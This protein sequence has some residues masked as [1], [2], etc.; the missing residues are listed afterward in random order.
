MKALVTGS[1]GL[2]GS[3]CVRMLSEL[4]WD[5]IGLENDM[6]RTFLGVAASTS[7]TSS[8]LRRT[9]PRFH[10]VNLDIRDRQAIRDLFQSERP[11]FIIHTAAQPASD[12]S[13]VIPYE[14][15]DVNATGTLNLLVAARDFTRDSPFCFTSTAKVYG[16][17]PNTIP[18]VMQ[19]SRYDFADARDGIDEA[20]PL[21]Q[22]RHS[23]FGVSKIAA[24]LLC[25][26]FGRYF[27]MPVGVFRCGG[28]TGPQHAAVELHGFLAYITQCAVFGREYTVFG[29]Q[30]KQVRDQLH[31]RDAARL[32]LEF[33]SSPRAGE[34]YNLG[35]GRPNSVSILETLDILE[36]SGH[37]VHWRY[38]N[39][40][41]CGDPICYISDL[42][43]IQAHYPDWQVEYRLKDIFDEMVA[44]L[45]AVLAS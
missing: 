8:F 38:E 12:K 10:Q 6:R 25:Q 34:V 9:C 2:I 5:V 37:R 17:H 40:P 16:D 15:F 3:E 14:D 24:D 20:L 28:I 11:Q 21:D 18:V 35:G 33:F 7:S 41:R 1:G 27:Q 29:Y 32:F 36:A 23:L 44:G 43:K 4:G 19:A 13:A 26:E 39:E 42:K 45:Q 22:G 31:C 30:G